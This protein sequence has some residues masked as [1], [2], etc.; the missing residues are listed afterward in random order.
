MVGLPNNERKL[1]EVYR[2]IDLGKELILVNRDDY[3][4][5]LKRDRTLSAL[6]AAGVDNWD[7][8]PFAFEND[9]EEEGDDD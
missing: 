9:D 8:Y 6:E 1:V 3:F 5:L 7:G 4:D 2:N